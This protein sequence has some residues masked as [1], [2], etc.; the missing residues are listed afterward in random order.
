MSAQQSRSRRSA[1][2]TARDM[3]D[4]ELEAWEPQMI[5]GA[6]GWEKEVRPNATTPGLDPG[7]QPSPRLGG[8]ENQPQDRSGQLAV[9]SRRLLNRSGPLRQ[10]VSVCTLGPLSGERRG[11]CDCRLSAALLR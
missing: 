10:N 4:A 3:V 1:W 2:L 7:D 5:P 8:A 11:G 6:G 9:G